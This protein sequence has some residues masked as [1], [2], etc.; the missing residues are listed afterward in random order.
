MDTP[1]VI[2]F[3]D[4]EENGEFVL[5]C[6][7]VCVCVCVRVRVCV[8]MCV[9]A[10]DSVFSAPGRKVLKKSL[11]PYSS[12]DDKYTRYFDKF[13]LSHEYIFIVVGCLVSQE[14]T[15]GPH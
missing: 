11:P 6:V 13:W 1:G 7:C 10:C 9:R 15:V 5:D 8:C 14:E 12:T 4:L 2:Y 3:D